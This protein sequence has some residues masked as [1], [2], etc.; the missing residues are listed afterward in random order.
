MTEQAF[1]ESLQDLIDKARREGIW[2]NVN[3]DA[4]EDTTGLITRNLLFVTLADGS[5]FCLTI[6]KSPEAK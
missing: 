2:N 4:V 1:T 3:A 6:Q 5:Q